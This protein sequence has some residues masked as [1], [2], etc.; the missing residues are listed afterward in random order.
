MS[1]WSDAFAF[2]YI[3]NRNNLPSS[4][5]LHRFTY[6]QRAR[7]LDSSLGRLGFGSALTLS[8]SSDRIAS[9]VLN[10]AVLAF[11]SQWNYSASGSRGGTDS[12]PEYALAQQLYL[13]M[14]KTL[15]QDA[16]T[17]LQDAESLT[18]SFRV[19]FARIIFSF[20]RGPV[21]T[22][23]Y[24][25]RQSS[26][27]ENHAIWLLGGGR[28]TTMIRLT[29]KCCRNLSTSPHNVFLDRKALRNFRMHHTS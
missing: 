19:I 27:E 21:D 11:A 20:I 24:S 12:S 8:A 10:K 1:S 28:T 9:Q 18:H 3:T 25:T 4:N 15:W 22:T 17:A 29:I 26:H 14:H 16:F 23:Q 13:T 2:P 5:G 6:Y 7:Q